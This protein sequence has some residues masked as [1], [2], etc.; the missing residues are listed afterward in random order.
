MHQIEINPAFL[1]VWKYVKLSNLHGRHEVPKVL[2]YMRAATPMPN[3][4]RRGSS[5]W[6]GREH[7]V[8][9]TYA[10]FHICHKPKLRRVTY[11]ITTLW[12]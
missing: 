12:S 6:C 11:V 3:V 4:Q 1:L 5:T 9:H 8:V 10:N 7:Y 2:F